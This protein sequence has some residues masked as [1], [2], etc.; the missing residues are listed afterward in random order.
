[1]VVNMLWEDHS[2][3]DRGRGRSKKSCNNVMAYVR[4]DKGLMT[5]RG[6]AS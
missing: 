6:K 4:D 5:V 3:V 1:M 2:A